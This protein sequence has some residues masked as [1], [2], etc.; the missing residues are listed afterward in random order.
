MN[1]T[2]TAQFTRYAIVGL[3]SNLVLYMLYLALTALG[4]G[5]KSAMTLLYVVG[6]AQ[7]FIFNKK[8]SFRHGGN[9]AGAFTRYATAYAAGYALNLFALW[10]FVDRMGVPHQIVQGI[11]IVTLAVF[12]FLAQKYWVF[13]PDM[14]KLSSKE[15][16]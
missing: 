10:L 13:T 11:M 5:Y 16:T 15:H 8:W 2:I 14:R 3:A 9:A 1:T 7:T 4:M 12:L 6:V